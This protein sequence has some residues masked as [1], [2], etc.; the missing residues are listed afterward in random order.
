MP[1]AVAMIKYFNADL[2]AVPIRRVDLKAATS[3]DTIPKGY[4]KEPL[5]LLEIEHWEPT[6]VA[7]S[8]NDPSLRRLGLATHCIAELER[9][10]LERVHAAESEKRHCKEPRDDGVEKIAS[11][12]YQ[13]HNVTFWIRATTRSNA[14]YWSRRGYEP[15]FVECFPAGFWGAKVDFEVMTLRKEIRRPSILDTR[16]NGV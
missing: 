14:P 12:P 15:L 6:A 16:A 3:N 11:G 13:S 8:P 5:E 2:G 4:K 1:V 7:I 10:L 9:D